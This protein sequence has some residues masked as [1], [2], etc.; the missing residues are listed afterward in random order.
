M[1]AQ[2]PAPDRLSAPAQLRHGDRF[3]SGAATLD[4]E[5][6]RFR[7]YFQYEL[8]L[9]DI[10]SVQV[11]RDILKLETP[12]GYVTLKLGKVARAWAAFI[13]ANR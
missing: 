8:A 4:R 7:G 2:D 12:G 9:A 13:Q 5:R 6:L 11:L 10:R 1:P 3:S